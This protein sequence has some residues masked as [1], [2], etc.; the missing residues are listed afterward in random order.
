[1][2]TGGHDRG[3]LPATPATFIT[4]MPIVDYVERS[5]GDTSDAFLMSSLLETSFTNGVPGV[6]VLKGI[7]VA[8]V[9]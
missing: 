8:C 6:P 3:G 1:M 9:H 4:S 2:K 7:D 5:S